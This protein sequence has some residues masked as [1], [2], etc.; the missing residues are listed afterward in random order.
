MV[1][2][3]HIH[4]DFHA[5]GLASNEEMC[6]TKVAWFINAALA[7][8]LPHVP[9][10]QERCFLAQHMYKPNGGLRPITIAET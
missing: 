6:D 9:C 2:K 8:S 10:G 5:A 7:G 1:C 3:Y 4:T